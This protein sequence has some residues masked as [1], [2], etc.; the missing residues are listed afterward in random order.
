MPIHQIL[1]AQRTHVK[2]TVRPKYIIQEYV[3]LIQAFAT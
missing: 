2:S 1:G 3:D